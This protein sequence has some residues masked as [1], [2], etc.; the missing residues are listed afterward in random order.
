VALRQAERKAWRTWANA[1]LACERGLVARPLSLFVEA[2]ELAPLMVYLDAAEFAWRLNGS[3]ERLAPIY[4]RH[5]RSFGLA[6]DAYP[7]YLPG[8]KIGP[9]GWEFVLNC[10]LAA[11]V[12]APG[13]L[14]V[15][16][17]IAD[18][19]EERGRFVEAL[20]WRRGVEAA[21][22]E[23]HDNA[24]AIG[25]LLAKSGHLAGAEAHYLR[26]EAQKPHNV[27]VLLRLISLIPEDGEKSKLLSVVDWI[28]REFSLAE[29][30][31]G[32]DSE[33]FLL[34]L[35]LE[36]V[37]QR[38][39]SPP[40]ELL[41][42]LRKRCDKLLEAGQPSL[43]ILLADA[44]LAFLESD[45]AV[46]ARRRL[47]KATIAAERA[48]T[49]IDI[50]KK[51]DE[52]IA[53]AANYAR[54]FIS[55]PVFPSRERE[56]LPAVNAAVLAR[57][58]AR[59]L[60]DEG[61][62]RDA[63]LKYTASLKPYY[64][65]DVPT[66]YELVGDHKLVLHEQRYYVFPREIQ[67]FTIC[68]GTVY[69]LTGIGRH[70]RR[71]IPAWLILL[72]FPYVGMY[73]NLKA[74]ARDWK[75]GAASVAHAMVAEYGQRILESAAWAGWIPHSSARAISPHA[76][77]A[78]RWIE[79]A[80]PQFRSFIRPA[81]CLAYRGWYRLFGRRS[82]RTVVRPHARG[83]FRLW[84][85]YRLRRIIRGQGDRLIRIAKALRYNLKRMIFN[86]SWSRYAVRDV[87]T[88]HRREAALA[89]IPKISNVPPAAAQAAPRTVRRARLARISALG[90]EQVAKQRCHRGE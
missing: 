36:I 46:S 63:L 85:N 87:V 12:S 13:R 75:A 88:A 61:K 32:I 68:E 47:C 56:P 23:S 19:L 55:R 44:L 62:A 52:P 57:E 31:S 67:E 84:F 60:L 50:S 35:V 34:G 78:M 9:E 81:V 39:L 33:V 37:R 28:D 41:Q 54:A 2:T 77:A 90:P 65:T 73:R 1:K 17:R 43:C 80:V 11:N 59:A 24:M 70:T 30:S 89:L 72:L 48:A 53:E 58:Q 49:S 27:E 29:K 40:R 71:H 45:F 14:D 4:Q 3:L 83:G 42:C 76:V 79:R 16:E 8:T 26:I 69:R 38:L 51:T 25:R 7:I 66:Q 82:E 20:A 21:D 22:P 64:V 74:K 15:R 10:L 18:L 6:P 5:A 86:I